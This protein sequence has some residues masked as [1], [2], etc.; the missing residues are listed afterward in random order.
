MNSDSVGRAKWPLDSM[1]EINCHREILL[2]QAIPKLQIPSGRFIQK[3]I[4]MNKW[5]IIHL[6]HRHHAI[7]IHTVVC[8]PLSQQNL[9]KIMKQRKFTYFWYILT[10][11]T[12]STGLYII[13][14][15]QET[16]NCTFT[17]ARMT[18]LQIYIHIATNMLKIPWR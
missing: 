11:Y 18:N 7:I 5:E 3:F 13:K 6:Q 8:I 16:Y 14:S 12:Y 2:R 15:E 9:M 10:I 17:T 4:Y 1:S